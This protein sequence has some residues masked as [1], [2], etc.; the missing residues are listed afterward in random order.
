MTINPNGN[1]IGWCGTPTRSTQ[2][3]ICP[4]PI[5]QEDGLDMIEMDTPEE[6]AQHPLLDPA[7]QLAIAA[8]IAGQAVGLP[9]VSVMLSSRFNNGYAI[10]SGV[11]DPASKSVGL[12]G[13][14][15]QGQL[16]GQVYADDSSEQVTWAG[17]SGNNYEGLEITVN[18]ERGVANV[19]GFLGQIPVRLEMSNVGNS[20]VTTG[21]LAETPF[22]T[23]ATL[24]PAD[25]RDG[26]LARL[27]VSGNLGDKEISK[28][29]TLS[30]EGD[31]N[32]GSLNIDGSG[33]NAGALY[34]SNMVTSWTTF[35][36]EPCLK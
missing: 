5:N 24:T 22:H 10:L 13:A 31:E 15:N 28:H 9:N 7:A 8:A 33:V 32:N 21:M 23:V 29:H 27:D 17:V 1:R 35:Q 26:I 34:E 12:A 19:R 4:E 36:L 14:V 16:Q 3:E 6:A 25:G 18:Q 20:L 11:P 2:P 30:L